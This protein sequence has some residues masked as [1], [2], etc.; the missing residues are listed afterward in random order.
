MQEL[1]H[2]A[3]FVLWFSFGCLDGAKQGFAWEGAWQS[4]RMMKP[5]FKPLFNAVVLS[6]R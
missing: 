3:L 4:V 1:R 5:I 6:A 2:K